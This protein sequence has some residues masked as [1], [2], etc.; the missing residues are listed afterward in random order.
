MDIF[1]FCVNDLCAFSF[2]NPDIGH[3]RSLHWAIVIIIFDNHIFIFPGTKT[4]WLSCMEIEMGRILTLVLVKS[5][6][7]HEDKLCIFFSC[8]PGTYHLT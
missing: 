6:C 3:Y 5:S 8:N 4:C 2:L 7:K 1:L